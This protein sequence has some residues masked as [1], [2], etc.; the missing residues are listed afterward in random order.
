M[1]GGLLS[2]VPSALA[3]ATSGEFA[4][5]LP[6]SFLSDSDGTI[7][8]YY[9]PTDHLACSR[10]CPAAQ[11]RPGTRATEAVDCVLIC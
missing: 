1:S 10:R 7:F 5:S 3:E 6:L 2:A 8:A 9:M 4:A 11:G